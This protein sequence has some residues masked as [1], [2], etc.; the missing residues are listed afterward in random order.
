MIDNNEGASAEADKQTKAFPIVAIGASAGGLEAVTELV[1]NLPNNTGMAF[2]FIQHLDRNHESALV[3]I[4]QRATKMPVMEVAEGMMLAPDHLYIIP[5]NCNMTLEESTFALVSRPATPDKHSPIDLFFLSLAAKNREG[6]IG[7]ILSGTASD[8]A[9]GL[10]AIK[11]AGGISFV[12]DETAQFQSMPKAAISAGVVDSVLSP[13]QMAQEITRLSANPSMLL[14]LIPSGSDEDENPENPFFDTTDVQPEDLKKILRLV[15]SVTGVDFTN[16]KQNTIRRRIIRRMLLQKLSSLH[17][18]YDYLKKNTQEAN[19]LYQDLLINVTHF[20]RD[21]EATD[22]LKKELLPELLKTKSPNNPLRIWV[23]ACA[24]GEEAYSLAIMLCE[25]MGEDSF[26]KSFQIFATDLSETAIAK[27]RVGMYTATDVSNVSQR[28]LELFF[29]KVDGHYRINKRIRDFCVFAPHNILKDPPFSRVDLISCCNL[30]IY[31]DT[32]LQRK[33][34]S[35]FHY[36]LNKKGYLLLGMSETVGASTNLFE[37]LDKKIKIYLKKPDAASSPVFD[38]N[39]SPE[40][41]PERVAPRLPAKAAIKDLTTTESVNLESIVDNI[42]LSQYVPAGVVVNYELDIVQ[43]RGSTGLFLEPSPGK[44]S[45][46]LLKMVRNGLEL[47]LRNAAHKVIKSNESIKVTGLDITHKGNIH[48]VAFEIIPLLEQTK[49]KLLLIIFEE[50]KTP[51]PADLKVSFSKDRRVK[52]LEAELIALRE[53]MRSLVEEQEA[54]NEELQ[55]ANEEIVSS[56]EELQ[57]I[58]EELETS[59]EELESSN[60]ELLTI[61]QEL[62]VRNDQ[63]SEAYDYTEQ[64]IETIR[65]AVIVLDSLLIVKSAN[66]AFY[67]TF[68][69]KVGEAEGYLIYE[70][71]DSQ[72]NIPKLK[73]LLQNIL[74]GTNQHYGYELTHLFEGIGE[75]VLL[76]SVK[77]IVQKT[78]GQQLILLAIEDITEHRQAERLLEEREQWLRN[79]ANNVPAMLWVAGPDESFTFVNKTWLAFTG[80][81]LNK[82]VGIGWTEGVF[83]D[84]LDTV[85]STFHTNFVE[86][87]PFSI[88]YRMKRSDGEFRWVLNNA[89]P[90]YDSNG[91]FS[92]YTG[93]CTEI[94]SKKILNEELEKRVKERTQELQDSNMNLERSNNELAQFAYVASH[95]LQEPLRK[96]ITFSTR[97]KER[98]LDLIP[99]QGKEYI[100]KINYSAERMRNLID[101]LLNFSRIT[102]FDKKFIKTDLNRVMRDVLGD[103][104]LLILERNAILNIERLPVLHV[105]PLQMNQLFHNLLSNALKFTSKSDVPTITVKC[106]TLPGQE[107]QHYN[108]LDKENK[109]YEITFSDNGIGFD[110]EFA[111]QIFVIFQRLNDKEDYPGT[112]IGLALCRKI[113]RN[114][115][116]E[117]VAKSEEGKGTTF[118][119]IL[120]VEQ[121][122]RIEKVDENS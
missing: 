53:D 111:D 7:I 118:Y 104:D 81:P 39:Y 72:W 78:S 64:V 89:V 36:A 51:S 59:K 44:A 25:I 67:R 11:E 42:L 97:L 87:K 109:Y 41:V 120:P 21:Q 115:G 60:E 119:I 102:R 116:G 37:S 52:Q 100:E 22:Y 58:N 75:K 26:Y 12:Q 79:M 80:R 107:L 24:T 2:V 113:V 9:L 43:F 92:G 8:G 14:K 98:F 56:N 62:Q 30:L 114:H 10:K 29:T 77:K 50:V 95:D 74:P 4:L 27:A 23:P 16:Y 34:I 117:I 105:I 55:S 28:R 99:N 90:T 32:V 5:P 94:H 121:L 19:L 66:K 91:E 112:G 70:V 13:H 38:V 15:R 63:L 103:F 45:L 6:S 47:E 1:Q 33:V 48:H 40:E 110:Q 86:Q 3:P 108:Q 88:E 93:S 20:F 54:A 82:E 85:V 49:E 65:E 18:Y 68:N 71:K 76:L 101:D 69:T 31:L 83:K 96:I 61:N 46:H 122:N 84:D 35:N 57:S 106:R 17:D 73:E